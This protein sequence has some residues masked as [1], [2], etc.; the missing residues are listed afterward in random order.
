MQDSQFLEFGARV[1]KDR[2]NAKAG[3]DGSKVCCGVAIIV[4]WKAVVGRSVFD[5][6]DDGD[7]VGFGDEFF[8]EP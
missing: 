4:I 7:K 3:V 2:V 5:W 6:F 8:V 1:L